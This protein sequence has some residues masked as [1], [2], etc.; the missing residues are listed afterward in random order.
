MMLMMTMDENKGDGVCDEEELKRQSTPPQFLLALLLVVASL[1]GVSFWGHEER[2]PSRADQSQPQE[3]NKT[4]MM[5]ENDEELKCHS[6][7]RLFLALV[8][9]V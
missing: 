6:A 5:D 1:F 8:L 3:K 9:G 4:M 7:P 2:K